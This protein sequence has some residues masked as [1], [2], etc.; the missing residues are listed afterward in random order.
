MLNEARHLVGSLMIGLSSNFRW[1]LLL[2]AVS[3]LLLFTGS[4]D[5]GPVVFVFVMAGWVVSI[6]IH[7]FGHA[8]V[9]WYGGDHAIPS[10]GYLT[11]DP[12]RYVD[13]I[14]S[15]LWPSLLV[16]IGAFGFPGGAVY[17][18]EAA[19][20]SDRWRSAVSAAGPFGSLLVF[21]VLVMPL[22]LG[23]DARLGA[24]TF[25]NAVALL[26]ELQMVGI[27]LNLLPIPGF[28]GY[29]ILEPHLP[30][31]LRR[32]LEPA[33][34]WA[35]LALMAVLVMVPSVG[36]SFFRAADRITAAMNVDDDMAWDGYQSF[37]FWRNIR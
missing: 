23:L 20:R 35:T 18:N 17:V 26:A 22:S 31:D 27:L 24:P 4:S 11:F 12:A 8:L 29:G 14:N 37:R 25:W 3:G 19:L 16:V 7:E 10:Q 2:V 33:K 30:V 28:D 32:S 9:A 34:A 13:P 21:V 6:C 5:A 36:G 1:L 15:L